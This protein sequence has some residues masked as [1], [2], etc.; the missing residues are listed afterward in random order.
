MG[1]VCTA[2]TAL[3]ENDAT[4]LQFLLHYELSFTELE[5]YLIAGTTGIVNIKYHC[6]AVSCWQCKTKGSHSTRV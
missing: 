1:Q 5:L 4:Q 6:N 2:R 3:D